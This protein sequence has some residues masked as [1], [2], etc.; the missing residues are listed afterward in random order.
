MAWRLRGGGWQIGKP[1]DEFIEWAAEN[2][3]ETPIEYA[4]PQTARFNSVEGDPTI[5]SE[6]SKTFKMT[7]PSNSAKA[8]AAM[9]FVCG[10][11]N[12]KAA[13]Q[14][15]DKLLD[16]DKTL[17][18]VLQE[19]CKSRWKPFE[20]MSEN[21]FLHNMEELARSIDTTQE[22]LKMSEPSSAAKAAAAMN[23]VC[24]VPLAVAPT[25]YD[26]IA[27]SENLDE[28]LEL[29]GY[30]RWQPFE[31]FSEDE[32]T[33]YMEELANSIDAAREHFK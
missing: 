2:H 10:I 19:H 26:A 20:N 31:N 24:G 8:V 4:I 29:N 5:E 16:T 32:F 33:E 12:F 23:F 7:T 13:V 11:R 15:Y 1:S 3:P 28:F 27:G 14:L 30:I 18:K 17:D 22:H 6:I 21:E 9:H 25:L